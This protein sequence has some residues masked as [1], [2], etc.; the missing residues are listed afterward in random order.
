MKKSILVFSHAMEIGGAER[1]L[2]GLLESIDYTRYEVDL[3]LM[4]HSGELMQ[5]IPAQVNLLPEVPQYA[6]LAVPIGE[7]LRKR[8]FGVACGRFIGKEKAKKRIRKLKLPA[9]NGVQLEYSHKYTRKWMPRVSEETYDLAI[10]FLTPHY[11]VAEKV[12]AKSKAAWIHTDYMAVHVDIESELEMW[13]RYD[14]IISISETV[15]ESFLKVFPSLRDK[16]RL[17][18]NIL[19]QKSILK[20]ADEFTVQNEMPEDG[21]IRLLS[22]GRFCRAKNYDNVP[23]ICRRLLDAG[24]SVT[25]YIIGYGGSEKL[26]RDKIAE[27][28]MQEHVVILG[29]KNNPYPYIKACDV[30]VQ[31]SRYEGNSVTVHEAQMLGKPVIITKYPT[32]SKQ[33]MDGVDGVIVPMENRPC[34]DRIAQILRDKELLIRLKENC[35]QSDYFNQS[36]AVAIEQLFSS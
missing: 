30:Y 17:I 2:L 25:W 13:G 3:F 27:A 34:A 8:Q 24:V 5:Y 23:D 32:S 4:R 9:D 16:I 15:T 19:P 6:A 35:L 20:Q 12:N 31:P 18:H 29:K 33:L 28:G 11:F 36:E 10:S 1:A 21:S 22:I 7:V 26:I 14:Y